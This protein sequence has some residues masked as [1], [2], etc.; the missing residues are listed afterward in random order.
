MKIEIITT[1]DEVVTG[2]IVDTNSSWIASRC[3][4]LGHEVKH[5]SSVIDDMGDIGDALTTAAKRADAVIVSGGL[6]PTSDDI[7]IEAAARTF[8]V[9]L[10]KNEDVLAE[11]REFFLRVG[12]PMSRS[13]DKQA[14]IPSGGTV[15]HNK[16][17]TAPGIQVKFR[18]AEFFFLPG[19]PKELYQIFDD[20]V[21]PWLAAHADRAVHERVL[22]CFGIPEASIAEKLAG[23]ELSVARLSYR[24]KFPEIV[25][26][27]VA[28]APTVSQAEKVTSAAAAAIKE[29]LGEIIYGEGDAEIFEVVGRELANRKFTIAVAESCTGGLLTSEITDVPGASAYFER[30]VVSY[31][32]RSKQEILG[33]SEETLRAHGAVSRETA[34]AM[35]EGIKRIS[36]TTFG[37]GITGIAGPDGGT[38]EKPVGTVHIALAAPDGTKAHEYH[39]NRDRAWF[40]KIVAWT[41]IDVVR[42]CLM[43]QEA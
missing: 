16:V 22:R 23:V 19:V 17:G 34:I 41:A 32:N 28:R 33:V 29:R 9:K 10:V 4:K 2:V 37:I 40:K 24:V 35:A 27:V 14:M 30:G 31:S 3:A 21:F 38:P 26:K 13:N 8:G 1:G 20:F 5:L 18:S 11:M 25:L 39:F 43:K 42:K 12:R 15:L 36:E 6:G 7:T